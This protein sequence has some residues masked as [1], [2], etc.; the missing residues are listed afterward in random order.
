MI[1]ACSGRHCSRMV[2]CGEVSQDAQSSSKKN[3]ACLSLNHCDSACS[4]LSFPSRISSSIVFAR[5]LFVDSP[6]RTSTIRNCNSGLLYFC[7]FCSERYAI[8]DTLLSL[9]LLFSAD[10]SPF[11]REKHAHTHVQREISHESSVIFTFR[12][13]ETQTC[14]QASPTYLSASPEFRAR[15]CDLK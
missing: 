9:L 8:L 10:L 2:S 5:T 13:E 1:H 12:R 7:V 11:N 15:K 3:I 6:C 14:T 4:T